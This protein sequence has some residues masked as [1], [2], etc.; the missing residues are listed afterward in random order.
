MAALIT[1]I[2]AI[3]ALVCAFGVHFKT[4]KPVV[5]VVGLGGLVALIAL[6]FGDTLVQIIVPIIL[7]LCLIPVFLSAL[8]KQKPKA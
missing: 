1:F 8:A 3:M 4:T 6:Y 2:A 5:A 7:F